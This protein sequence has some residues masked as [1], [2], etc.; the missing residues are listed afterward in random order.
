MQDGSLGWLALAACVGAFALASL[1]WLRVAQREHYIA[2]SASRFALRWW[3]STPLNAEIAALAAAGLVL[4]DRWAFATFATAL[5][6]AV[7]PVGLGLRGR[8]APLAW[9]RRLETLAATSTIVGAL[10]I[11]IGAWLGDAPLA[12]AAVALGAPAIVDIACRL[13]GPLERRLAGHYVRQASQR[14]RAVSPRVV[15]ITGSYGKTST[16]AAVAHLASGAMAV[17]ATPASFNNEAGLARSINEHLADG[18]EVFVAE[19][20]TYGPGEIAALCS[21]VRPDISAITAIGPVHLERFRTEERIVSAKS[22]ILERAAKVVLPVDDPRLGELA[23]RCRSQGKEVFTCATLTGP[24]DDGGPPDDAG[25]PEPAVS[26]PSAD[27]VVVRT[28]ATCSVIAGDVTL[29]E[30]LEVPIRAGN[31]A[32]AVATALALGV[33]TDHLRSRI[34]SIPPVAH[35]LVKSVSASGV[36]VLDDTYNS[37]PAGCSAALDELARSGGSA[38]RVVV[39]PGMVELG[40]RQASENAAFAAAAGTKATHLI[41]VGR[42]NRRALLAGARAAGIET[43]SMRTREEAVAWV[44]ENLVTGDAVLYENDLPD[45][46]P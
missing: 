34:A 12:S 44:R 11:G 22:E 9:T 18:T 4:G 1:R 28:G 35:R 25:P 20:G 32:C 33:P 2:D 29:G 27:V 31:L 41:V 36:L 6:T 7:G 23:E 42:T 13:T 43:L 24:A 19:M 38:K 16:K 8:S 37:N 26:M 14:L 30:C 40:P 10:G 21:W 3:S 46:Y 15:A 17:V 45:H 5:C 39:T